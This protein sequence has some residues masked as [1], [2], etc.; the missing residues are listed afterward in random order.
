[1][2][3]ALS[4]EQEEVMDAIVA[5]YGIPVKKNQEFYLAGY[6]GTGKT[7]I[8]ETAISIIKDK[9]RIK[10]VVTAAYTGKAAS[11]LQNK[12]VPNAMTVHRMLYMPYQDENGELCFA[13]RDNSDAERADLIVLD[14]ISMIGPEIA[15]DIRALGVKILVIGDPGQL[16]PI[17]KRGDLSFGKTFTD[18]EPDRFLKQIHR[19]A[20]DSPILELATMAR[21]GIK[22]PIGYNKGN[23]RVLP[24][25]W[26]NRELLFDPATQPICGLNNNRYNYTQSIRNNLGIH[27]KEPIPGEKIMCC[28]TNYKN[29]FFNGFMG[30]MTGISIEPVEIITDTGRPVIM[31]E[32]RLD[33]ELE[34]MPS[35]K[36]KVLID[37]YLFQ[38]HFNGG[39]STP[40]PFNTANY[41]VYSEFDWA[42]IL[43]CHKA[44]GSQFE[45][46]TVIDDS[47]AF[48]T[49]KNK[50]LYTA[51]TRA[52]SG[53]TILRRGL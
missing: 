19:Q 42:Y 33:V 37:P 51:L 2:T 10:K 49:D 14:E 16:P 36:H 52:V 11:V 48:K 53:L 28:K 7:T 39:K 20:A 1:M 4:S 40:L 22:L 34:D 18:R 29:G 8:V 25:N 50:W 26:Q 17:K 23:V 24:L 12:G 47:D 38:N 44:Q 6:A 32:W 41:G 3:V 46:V 45:H 30:T 21:Q 15:N 31:D 43:T 9:H 13:K 27:S 35:P 5:W